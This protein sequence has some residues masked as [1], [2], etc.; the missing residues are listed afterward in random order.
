MVR[1]SQSPAIGFGKAVRSGRCLVPFLLLLD[2]GLALCRLEL[3]DVCFGGIA[4]HSLVFSAELGVAF[5]ADLKACVP[6][7]HIFNEHKSPCFIETYSF[8]KL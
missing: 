8:L 5:I 7:V 3:F 6:C 1:K 4:K 2:W